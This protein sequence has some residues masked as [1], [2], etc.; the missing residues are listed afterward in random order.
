MA[1]PVIRKFGVLSALWV[2][3]LG[4]YPC[5][6]EGY[7]VRQAKIIRLQRRTFD[8]KK[9]IRGTQALANVSTMADARREVQFSWAIMYFTF[10]V[11]ERWLRFGSGYN[12]LGKK[13]PNSSSLPRISRWLLSVIEVV[14]GE[15]T[16]CRVLIF[17]AHEYS[18]TPSLWIT[19]LKCCCDRK[20]EKGQSFNLGRFSQSCESTLK[21]SADKSSHL[22]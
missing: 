9:K 14:N 5:G 3:L 11:N 19:K 22:L 1:D 4:P 20:L 12:V 2:V 6:Y 15:F 21:W 7:P 8:T 10:G 17:Y 18:F 13:R 16:Y